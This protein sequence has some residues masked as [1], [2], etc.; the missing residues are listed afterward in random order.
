MTIPSLIRSPLTLWANSTTNQLQEAWQSTGTIDNVRLVQGDTIAVELHWLKN[1]SATNLIHDEVNWPANANIT[2]AIGLLDAAP[3]SG[4]FNLS[5]NGETTADIPAGATNL[6]VQTALNALSTITAEGGVTVAKISTTYKVIW[7]LPCV[8]SSSLT[9]AYNDLLPNSTIGLGLARAGTS[10]VSAIYQIH[11]KQAPVAVCT[12]WEDDTGTE[13]AIA[14]ETTV[15]AARTWLLS[16]SKLP[17]SGTFTLTYTTSTGKV[18]ISSPISI[19]NI[20]PGNI[21]SAIMGATGWDATHYASAVQRSPLSYA[22]TIT[23]TV[24]SATTP[25][26]VSMVVSNNNVTDFSAKIG[27]LS[28]NTVEVETLLAG[29]ASAQAVLEVEV[30]LDNSR[31]TIV[32]ANAFIV[33]DL[34]DAD[35][36]DLVEWGELMPADS[37]VRF[38]TSQT[39]TTPQKTQARTNIG[40]LGDSSLDALRAKDAELELLLGAQNLTSDELAAIHGALAPASTN[41]FLTASAGDAAYAAISHTHP[42]SEVIDLQTTLD[43][44]ANDVAGVL[45]DITDLQTTKADVY[46]TQ[47]KS[48]I[49]GLEAQL[50]AIELSLAGFAP[51]IHTHQTTDVDNLE[52]RL[53]SLELKTVYPLSQSDF[54]AIDLAEMPS[55]TNVFVTQSRADTLISTALAGLQ[56]LDA[57]Q[58]G[59]LITAVTNPIITDV[60]TL[61]SSF[62]TVGL[63]YGSEANTPFSGNLTTTNY[64]LE[65]TIYINGGVYKVPMRRSN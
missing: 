20:T 25:P 61:S 43:T 18:G 19:V 14:I 41:L 56:Y 9:T 1:V 65:L 47:A 10:T 57:V 3:I 46:H 24:S 4:V 55:S 35:A 17:R 6:Q 38:D 48:T 7:N 40:A 30:S 59:A 2:L 37:V 27:L 13:L 64:P 32:Q 42:I 5:Y 29:G 22:I 49:T 28:M 45:G 21:A 53:A 51:L 36:Y 58:V 15:V 23:S 33:N 39:L 50:S 63:K 26:V 16:F 11:I 31:Q 34:I 8:L 54:Q 44:I 12:S 62:D 60:S 52:P